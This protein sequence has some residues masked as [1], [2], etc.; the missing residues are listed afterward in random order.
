MQLYVGPGRV[1]RRFPVVQLL[2]NILGLPG[3]H[4]YPLASAALEPG[5]ALRGESPTK[6]Q[7]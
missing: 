1:G 7:I 2:L 6:K 3:Q 5:N 4:C